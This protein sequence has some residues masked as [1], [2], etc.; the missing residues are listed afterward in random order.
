M[1]DRIDELLDSAIA[2]YVESP[3][4]GLELRVMKRVRA[5]KRSWHFLLPVL[6][7]ATLACVAFF[8][9]RTYTAPTLEFHSTTQPPPVI[10]RSF[11]R[12][13]RKR[14]VL[15]R[16]STFPMATPLTEGER[17]LLAL[18]QI[19]PDTATVVAE[20]LKKANSDLPEIEPLEIAPLR[21][22]TGQ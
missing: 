11:A 9:P 3:R 7:A 22:E 6:A 2:T 17:A 5:K 10:E 13:I 1:K 12:Q 14:T 20:N 18:A 8:F 21:T 16:Q 15:P 4:P 19:H